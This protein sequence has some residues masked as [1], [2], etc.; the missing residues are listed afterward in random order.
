MKMLGILAKYITEVSVV[1]RLLFAV[2]FLDSQLPK[3]WEVVIEFAT[4]GRVSKN[5][6]TP[7]IAKALV[8]NLR[9]L[10]KNAFITDETL[11]KELILLQLPGKPFGKPLISPCTACL[12]CG[13]NLQLRKDRPAP[14]VIYDAKTGTIPGAHFHKFCPQRTCSFIQYYGYYTIHSKVRFNSNWASLPYFLSSRDTAFSLDTLQ[15]LDANILIGQLSFKQQADI[16]N[17][18]QGY[19]K[20]GTHMSRYVDMCN[21]C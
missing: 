10:N 2:V 18:T 17:Y 6:V 20:S 7:D 3:F 19:R 16:Y 15:Y 9:L 4:E 5:S 1:R 11:E 21:A 14:V 8:E 13:S 12:Q